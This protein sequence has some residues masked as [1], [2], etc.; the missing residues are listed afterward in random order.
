MAEPFRSERTAV[1]LAGGDSARLSALTREIFGE[2]MPGQFCRLWGKYTLLEQTLRRAALVIDPSR[3]LTVLTAHHARW[4]EPLLS[5]IGAAGPAAVQP[6][7]RG[8]APAILYALMRLKKNAPDCAVALFPSGHFVGDDRTFMSRVEAAFRAVDARPE[9]TVLLGLEPTDPDPDYGWI[10]AGQFLTNECQP[11]RHVLRFWEKPAPKVA[12]RLYW[13]GCLWNSFVTVAR[14]STFLGLFLI[15]LPGLYKTFTAIESELGTPSE[16][17][18]V[19]HLYS[20]IWPSDFSREVLARCPINLAVLQ[21]SG[22]EWS[23]LGEPQ[24]VIRLFA[25][26]AVPPPRDVVRSAQQGTRTFGNL[27]SVAPEFAISE[28]G[29]QSNQENRAGLRFQSTD[30]QIDR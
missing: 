16:Q 27:G 22:V 11:V 3:T 28:L 24:R 20:R 9:A 8:T 7:N 2:E 29:S 12:Q 25:G 6:L 15:T 30:P 21:V 10:E 19:Q 14:L 26:R 4:Y 18:R 5:S 1:I 13:M 17:T 23:D